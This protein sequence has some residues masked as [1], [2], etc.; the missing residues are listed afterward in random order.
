MRRY[1]LRIVRV[2]G[3]RLS[4]R[5]A[6]KRKHHFVWGR[7]LK[8]WA[9]KGKDIYYLTKKG[10][11]AYDS[12]SGLACENDFYKVAPLRDVD[13]DFILSWSNA[14]P[15][16]LLRKLHRSYLSQFT[17]LTSLSEQ[18]TESGSADSHLQNVIMH[19]TLED[20]HSYFETGVLEVLHALTAGDDSV[21]ND[22]DAMLKFCA[23]L[24]HQSTRTRRMKTK[25]TQA[26][27]DNTPPEHQYYAEL[28]KQNWWFISYMLGVNLGV[29]L[30]ETRHKDHHVFVRNN[31]DVPFVTS[32]S[33]YANIHDCMVE[34]S[35]LI[36]PENADFFF[37]LSPK[38]GYMI[39]DSD[40]YDSLSEGISS[41]MVKVL[42][43]KIASN[44]EYHVFGST[45]ES[46]KEAIRKSA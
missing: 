33:P 36:S 43:Q 12:V 6:I 1:A 5:Q 8:S 27:F 18:L 46:I 41:E 32:D 28:L 15:S 14:S 19:N 2:K 45:S 38:Y 29:N 42:N 39:N 35:A 24:G 21:L 26:I 4:N 34:K 44:R 22:D 31:T 23:Y 16:P 30:F 17:T 37:P 13:V 20:L 9:T 40:K 10:G 11:I 7:Y 3:G 25:V